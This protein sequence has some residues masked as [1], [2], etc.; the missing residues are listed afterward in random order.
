MRASRGDQ[1][2]RDDHSWSHDVT[3][4]DG[5]AQ[6]QRDRL[7]GEGGQVA[8]GGEATVEQ[9][10]QYRQGAQR[11]RRGPVGYEGPQEPAGIDGSV[12]VAVDQSRQQHAITEFDYL[13]AGAVDS[14]PD[15]G[16]PTVA[17]HHLGVSGGP[18]RQ[19]VPA[20]SGD[21]HHRALF[22]VTVTSCHSVT[23]RLRPHQMSL[24]RHWSRGV[25]GVSGATGRASRVGRSDQGGA[26]TVTW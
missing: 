19:S 4:G 5:V 11:D 14:R 15:L 23:L 17:H 10:T 21:Q 1:V 2:R 3:T 25:Q 8:D 7:G 20:P 9:V 12:D 6:V 24:A 26:R 16:D 18:V 22:R 13:G